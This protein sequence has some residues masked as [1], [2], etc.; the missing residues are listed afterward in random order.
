[1]VKKTNTRKII[2]ENRKA[3]YNYFLDEVIESGLILK[4]TEVKS[5][6]AGRANIAESYAFD[7][8]GEI[9]LDNMY[10]GECTHANRWNHD[11]RRSRKLLLNRRQIN[12]L[13]GAVRRKGCTLVPLALYFNVKGFA[14]LEIALA[15]GKKN[16]DKRETEKARDWGREKN[17][18]M[19]EHRS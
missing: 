14:K 11:A 18:L 3:R 19:R 13:I 15:R 7:R 1:M 2:A 16:H 17:R 6:R 9:W 5:L 10:I 12:R 4:G 8:D